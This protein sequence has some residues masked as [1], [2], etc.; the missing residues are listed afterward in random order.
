MEEKADLSCWIKLGMMSIQVG[1][2][3]TFPPQKGKVCALP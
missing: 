2:G 3:D 1:D